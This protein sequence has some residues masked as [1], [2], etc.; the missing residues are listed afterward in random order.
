MMDR[1]KVASFVC[2][3][4]VFATEW[5]TDNAERRAN[6]YAT[7]LLLPRFMF[8]LRAKNKDIIFDTVRG[9]A[10]NFQVSLTATAIRLVELGSF[11]AMV[12]CNE[13]GRRR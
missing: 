2:S 10:R 11:S 1:G 7:D 4:R 12:V 3:E 9:L 6:R 5:E 13:P 8:E